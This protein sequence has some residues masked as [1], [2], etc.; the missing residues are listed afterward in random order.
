MVYQ[1]NRKSGIGVKED[2]GEDA[3]NTTVAHAFGGSVRFDYEP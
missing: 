1:R 3:Q 2:G